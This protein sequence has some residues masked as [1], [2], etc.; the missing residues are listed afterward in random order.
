MGKI[1]EAL[2][3]EITRLAR[4]ELRASVE[5]L[6]REVRQLR[7]TVARLTK[8]V[9]GLDKTAAIEVGRQPAAAAVPQ[10]GAVEV[11]AA[12]ISPGVI[13]NLRKKLGL[14]QENLAAI[15][16]VTPGA[17]AAWE[18][19]RARPRGGNKAALVGLRKLGR[20]DV[21]RILAKR[22]IK[23]GRKRGGKKT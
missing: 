5:P 20:R 23:A 12:R 8:I 21:K 7:R 19:G 18:Q 22:G 11:R 17:V 2:K 3:S 4:K 10:A 15:L 6:T 1:E 14:N 13:K 16:G 9:A